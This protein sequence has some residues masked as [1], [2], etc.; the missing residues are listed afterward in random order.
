MMIAVGI[1]LLFAA[2]GAMAVFA[3]LPLIKDSWYEDENR[4][5]D[6]WE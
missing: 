6:P 2:L 5:R 4:P 3:L 1:L